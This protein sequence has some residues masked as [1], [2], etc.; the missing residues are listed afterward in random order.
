MFYRLHQL[1]HALFPKVDHTEYA[2]LHS[3]L[4]SDAL[5]LFQRQT[6]TEQRHALDVAQDIEKQKESIACAFGEAQYQNLLQAALL[7]DCG[8]SL[9]KLHLW[10]RIFIVI[11]GYLPSQWQQ[12]LQKQ[13]NI[14]GKTLLVYIQ[15]P[16]WGKHFASQAGVNDQILNLI[17]KHHFPNS[18]LEIL[19]YEADN[20]H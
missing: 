18:P 19:L 9:F 13:S 8:K 12:I 7:H 3:I 6:L 1:Y 2:W 16:V 10:Q 11:I 20:R 14:F 4:H 15:H 5:A 17:E